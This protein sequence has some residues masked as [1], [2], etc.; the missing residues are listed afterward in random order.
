MLRAGPAAERMIRT[1]VQKRASPAMTSQPGRQ[2][3]R[4]GRARARRPIRPGSRVRRPSQGR[5]T[6]GRRSRHQS[7]M[8]SRACWIT[9]RSPTFWISLAAMHSRWPAKST[10]SQRLAPRPS[11]HIRTHPCMLPNCAV[12]PRYDQ[13]MSA[14]HTCTAAPLMDE[15]A[16]PRKL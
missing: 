10:P 9:S 6:G 15:E 7:R 4:A 1:A 12:A 11:G 3:L 8:P 16:Y 5:M 14:E 13:K 2:A